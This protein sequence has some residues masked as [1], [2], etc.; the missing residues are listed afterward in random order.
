MNII[1][2]SDHAGFDL[3]SHIMAHYADRHLFTDCGTHS[4]ESVDY[5]DFAHI[6][7][8]KV[9]QTG[10]FG[11]LICGTGNGVAMTANKHA[12]IRAAV[13]WKEDIAILARQHNNANVLVLPARH[14]DNKTAFKM[15]D[16]FFATPFEKGRHEQRV[17]K[18][19]IR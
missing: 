11:I 8:E 19:D 6:L 17:Q 7:A 10:D 18:I 14:V 5:P 15:I 2:A 4:A 13:C 12:G 16:L 3:K 1:I 9:L